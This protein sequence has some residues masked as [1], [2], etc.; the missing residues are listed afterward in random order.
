MTVLSFHLCKYTPV[1]HLNARK[2]SKNEIE[3]T[4]SVIT[5]QSTFYLVVQ[6]SWTCQTENLGF[7]NIEKMNLVETV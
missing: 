4:I 5:Y 6:D 7:Y 2:W 3:F 1:I